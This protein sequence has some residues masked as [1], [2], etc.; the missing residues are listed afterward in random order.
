MV[1]TTEYEQLIARYLNGEFSGQD[2]AEIIRWISEKPENKK[3]FLE[4]KDT[5]D[6]SLKKDV[7]ETEQ[8]LQFYKRQVS[9]KRKSSYPAWISG[10]AVAAILIVGVII[11]SLLQ[12]NYPGGQ[13]RLESFSVPMGSRSQLTLSDGTVVSL[14]SASRL[15]PGDNF[16]SRNR[17]V[18]LIG[19]AYFEVKADK[20]HPFT[21]KT[22]KFTIT[23][24]GTKF[25]VSSYSDD[26]KISATLAEGR[27]K[28]TTRGD[29]KT[30]TLNPG[31]KIAFN[32]NTM[33]AVLEKA[34]IESE[35]AWI[36]GEFI[37]KEIPFPDLI[38]RL[39]R[40]YDVRLQYKG[41]VFDAMTYS[42]KFK[43]QET[44][45]QVL[46]ALKLTTS[47]DYKKVNDREF[48]LNYKHMK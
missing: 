38:R 31:E 48:E 37:F 19:E 15:E 18:M 47:I 42:G 21:V 6:A 8:L 23:V 9:R 32:Q 43:N 22:E 25:N 33:Q 2:E 46:D 41:N 45:W 16:S 44:I 11:G 27:I 26:Q 3:I 40:W 29:N 30:I 12:N 39:E 24:T 17:E 1:N 14:N 34:D 5:W 20:H 10:I 28:L 35:M 4:V 36:N 13:S 7:S